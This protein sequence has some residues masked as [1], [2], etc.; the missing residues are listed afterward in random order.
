MIALVEV[1]HDYSHDCSHSHDCSLR[2]L[3]SKIVM[4]SH[5]HDYRFGE[6]SMTVVI[7]MTF[8]FFVLTGELWV[9]ILFSNNHEPRTRG[10]DTH[11]RR[12]KQKFL[13]CPA[14]ACIGCPISASFPSSRTYTTCTSSTH[15]GSIVGE[16]RSN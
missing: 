4:T 11:L 2:G 5:S 6:G 15:A 10:Q 1:F 13:L 16:N 8:T 12:K 9:F 7:V 14:T 3:Q